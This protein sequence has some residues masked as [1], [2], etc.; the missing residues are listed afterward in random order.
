MCG[1]YAIVSPN[2]NADM[3]RIVSR[4]EWGKGMC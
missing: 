3:G 1:S 2:T 4:L